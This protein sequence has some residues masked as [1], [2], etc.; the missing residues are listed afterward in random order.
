MLT[1]VLVLAA[2]CAGAALAIVLRR[3]SPPP[4]F[5]VLAAELDKIT[6]L[7]R[8]L[9][10]ERATSF[11]A[12][13]ASIRATSEQTGRLAETTEQLRRALGSAQTRGQWGERMAE[14]VLRLAGFLE[15]VNYRR[16]RGVRGGRG[17]PDFTFLLPRGLELHMDVKFPLDNYLRHLEADTDTERVH[18]RVAFLRDVRQRVRELA[19]RDYL[20]GDAPCVD[21]LLLFLP[22]EQLYAF[23]QEQAPGLLDEALA[24]KVVLCSPLTLFAVLAV[25]R[26]AVD[27][28]VLEQTADEILALLGGFATQWERFVAQMDKLG[29]RLAGAQQDF[30]DLVGTRRRALER[31]LDRLDD[32][33]RQRAIEPAL[34]DS[35]RAGA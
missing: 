5:A 23:V 11:G 4:E 34:S 8:D 33:R 7:V 2:L 24:S 6:G 1:A 30:D 26:Q 14:D 17:I 13:S 15:H 21:C 12:L 25:I 20:D 16:Q 31:P 29:R 19:A 32:L 28:F 18:Y 35:S 22:N 3:A 9:D 27:A 10:R